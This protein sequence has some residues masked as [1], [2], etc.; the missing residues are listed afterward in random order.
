MSAGHL[1]ASLVGSL[2]VFCGF[3]LGASQVACLIFAACF[4]PII[5]W[6]HKGRRHGGNSTS[7]VATALG[8]TAILLLIF[9]VL[10][11]VKISESSRVP[12]KYFIVSTRC[13]NSGPKQKSG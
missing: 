1:T 8:P 12:L 6:T 5:L 11:L 2:L 4:I 13:P 7:T 10:S 3:N 9:V